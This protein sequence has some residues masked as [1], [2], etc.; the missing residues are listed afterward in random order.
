MPTSMVPEYDEYGRPIAKH[1]T[2]LQ[3]FLAYADS[4][5]DSDF[6]AKWMAEE[7]RRNPGEWE[8]S[9][10]QPKRKEDWLARNIKWIGP[11]ALGALPGAA[12]G[13]SAASASGGGAAAAGGILPSSHLPAA[14]LM[15]GP[16]AI[17]NGA[18]T[19]SAAGAAGAAGGALGKIGKGLAEGAAGQINP[20]MQAAF[21]AMSGLPAL[22]A[23]RGPSDEE[24]GLYDQARQLTQLQQKRMESQN[25]LFDAV[26]QLAMSRLPRGGA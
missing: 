22:M 20:W 19:G 2:T 13:G 26:T 6:G 10:G 3:E 7:I 21:A 9:Q 11:A 24:R 14:A 25:P 18:V 4:I 1:F 12:A 8:L 23:N 17:A 5:A 16:G 15:G